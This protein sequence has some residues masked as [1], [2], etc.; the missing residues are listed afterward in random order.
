MKL[1]MF[2]GGLESG[3]E[4]AAKGTS[5]YRNGKEEA[6]TRANPATVIE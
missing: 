3:D 2:E 5:Q 1:T 6:R 4:L